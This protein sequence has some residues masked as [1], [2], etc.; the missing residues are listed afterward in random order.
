MT[1][2]PHSEYTIVLDHNG[3]VP[4]YYQVARELERAITEGRIERGGFL[5]NEVELSDLWHVSRP[6]V[7]RAIQELVDQGLLVR[8]RGVGTQAVRP[9]TRVSSL[10]DELQKAGRSPAS[11]VLAME[12]VPGDARITDQLG[13][14]RGATVLYLERCRIVDGKHLAIIRNWVTSK[15][16]DD[17]TVDALMAGGLYAYLR[18]KGCFPHYATQQVGARNASPVDAALLGLPVGGAVL[19]M[20]TCMQDRQGN[21]VDTGEMICDAS[22]YSVDLTVVEA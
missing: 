9:T 12:L 20:R 22:A 2:R 7:R 3:P 1:A 17:L 10:F 14:Q 19:T 21:K 5:G 16:V 13:L 11:A 18:S 15:F 6:T 8:Q 4:L